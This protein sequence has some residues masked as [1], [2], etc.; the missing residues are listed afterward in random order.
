MVKGVCMVNGEV[1]VV[2]GTMYGKGQAWREMC[3]A[4]E[5]GMHSRGSMH[6]RGHASQG[7]VWHG[8]MHGRGM[9]GRSSCMQE[10]ATEAGGTHPTGMHF[11][12]KII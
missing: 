2:K 9:R 8:G 7:H 5:G 4:K 10:M 11:C 1:C 6:G 12:I 3:M